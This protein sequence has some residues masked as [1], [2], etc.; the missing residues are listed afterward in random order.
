MVLQQAVIMPTC[1]RCRPS[2]VCLVYGVSP[3]TFCMPSLHIPYTI[4]SS[5]Q[6]EMYGFQQHPSCTLQSHRSHVSVAKRTHC[7]ST[8]S[9]YPSLLWKLT[10]HDHP[11][12]AHQSPYLAQVLIHP[13]PSRSLVG[14][15]RW[16]GRPPK[17]KLLQQLWQRFFPL[18]PEQ[19]LRTSSK[20]HC[21]LSI[22]HVELS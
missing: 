15:L 6:L 20:P 18:D 13:L 21:Q 12:T 7:T 3:R 10:T 22:R 5:V 9:P 1:V 4:I 2:S 11:P 14:V 8:I 17:G 19:L 16:P